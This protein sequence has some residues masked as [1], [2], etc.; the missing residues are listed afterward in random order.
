MGELTQVVHRPLRQTRYL[1]ML[2]RRA[3]QSEDTV[4]EPR[5][6][7]K[8]WNQFQGQAFFGRDRSKDEDSEK[9]A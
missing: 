6:N 9:G 4:S 5:L 1:L 8:P 3:R 2:D 7:S